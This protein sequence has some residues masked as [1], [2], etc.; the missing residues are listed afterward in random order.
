MKLER[1]VEERVKS[2]LSDNFV[3]FEKKAALDKIV[4]K[5]KALKENLYTKEMIASLLYMYKKPHFYP[6]KKSIGS[7]RKLSKFGING[8]HAKKIKTGAIDRIYFNEKGV[9][10]I[11]EYYYNKNCIKKYKKNDVVKDLKSIA[12]RR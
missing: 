5:D 6:N 1:I 4:V 10:L 3:M 2:G 11:L 8:S 12:S 9:R 7:S